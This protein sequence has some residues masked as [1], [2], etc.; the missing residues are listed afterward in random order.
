MFVGG[1]QDEELG[2]GNGYIL[3]REITSSS[4]QSASTP[5]KNARLNYT[6]GSSWCA[7]ANDSKPYLQ[8]E[9][10]RL[11]IICAVSTQGNSQGDQWVK[12]Y[13]L[14][15]SKD[16]TNWTDY[17]EAGVVKI[18]DG[19]FDGNNTVRQSLCNGIVTTRL[20]IIAQDHHGNC[21][22]RVELYGLPVRSDN[23]AR[24]NPTVQSSTYTVK[25]YRN[26]SFAVD[27]FGNSDP[28]KCTHTESSNGPW[29]RV[30]LEELLPVSEV[31]ILNR[32]DCCGDRL[33]GFEIRVGNKVAEGGSTNQL[34]AGD[35][36][37]P[38]GKG[39]YFRCTS[40]VYGRYVYIRIPGPGK[41]LTLCEV[42]VYSAPTPTGDK[43][44]CDQADW[45][46]SLDRSGWSLCPQKNTYLKGLWRHNRPAVCNNAN[47]R[48]TL[49]G[50]NVWALC[51]DGFFLNGLYKTDGQNLYNIEEGQCCRPL[52]QQEDGYDDCYEEDVTT[53]FDNRGWSDCQRTGYYM[54]GIYKSNC[55]K[56]Y[57][58]EIF[59]CCRMKTDFSDSASVK[60]KN[61]GRNEVHS[62]VYED[63]DSSRAEQR[64]LLHKRKKHVLL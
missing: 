15:S 7:A 36:S 12:T 57:C 24:D 45:R 22:M 43:K 8:I 14:Q 3:D 4:V 64:R 54:T 49:Y 63:V 61:T 33:K 46:A 32:R 60:K 47:W 35:L 6:E 16:G 21:C 25:G 13:T 55:E 11:F 50:N 39:K 48:S 37:V 53:S 41:I 20:R 19:N 23:V 5:A 18:F 27:G 58:I 38:Q 28:L 42:E 2:M 10:E 59:K 62:E 56:I 44:Q 29:W 1:C 30:D 17:Q 26:S 40:T 9:L 31:Y 34:C 51:P 52:N